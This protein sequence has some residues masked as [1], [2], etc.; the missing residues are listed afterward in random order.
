MN[1]SGIVRIAVIVAGLWFA[2]QFFS[3]K[4]ATAQGWYEGAAG[5][6]QAI[7]AQK[8]NNQPILLYF[9][10]DWCGYCKKLDR[11]V[12]ATSKFGNDYRSLLKVKVNPEKGQ[13]ESG[14]A[15]RYRVRGYPTVLIVDSRSAREASI[16]YG[17]ADH[18]YASLQSAIER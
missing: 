12:L 2:W 5:F 4:K 14:L 1:L 10:T 18:F 7:A 13:A 8:E 17:S 3:G 9:Y 11:D 16:G 6:D 15:A